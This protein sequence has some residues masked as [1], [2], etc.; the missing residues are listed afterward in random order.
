[1][2]HTRTGKETR[3]TR[4]LRLPGLVGIRP[5]AAHQAGAKRLESQTEHGSHKVADKKKRHV[6]HDIISVALFQQPALRFN[7]RHVSQATWAKPGCLRVQPPP[8]IALVPGAK[9]PD[10]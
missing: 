1:M 10:W 4:L 8:L 3:E 2:Q 6:E 5:Q 7:A 9:H